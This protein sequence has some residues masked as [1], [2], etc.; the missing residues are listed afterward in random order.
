VSREQLEQNMRAIQDQMR[1]QLE[2]DAAHKRRAA[3]IQSE[4]TTGLLRLQLEAI[5]A[6]VERRLIAEAPTAWIAA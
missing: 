4:L 2:A 1:A 6:E 5:D 3:E